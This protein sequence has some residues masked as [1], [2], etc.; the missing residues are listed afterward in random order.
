MKM[1]GI[2]VL[3]KRR[4]PVFHREAAAVPFVFNN[5]QTSRWKI[6]VDLFLGADKTLP[7]YCAATGWGRRGPVSLSH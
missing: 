5:L 4:F 1:G 3:S 7:S 6:T 2:G